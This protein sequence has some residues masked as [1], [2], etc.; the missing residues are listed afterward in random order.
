MGLLAMASVTIPLA[1]LWT[2]LAIGLGRAQNR[3]A[4][5]RRPPR[6]GVGTALG[7]E[8]TAD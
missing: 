2:G 4:T 1:A 3:I 8:A 6:H 5:G 7:G